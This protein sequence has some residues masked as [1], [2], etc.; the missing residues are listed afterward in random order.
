MSFRRY[1]QWEPGEFVVVG[2]DTATGLGDYCTAQFLS[3]TK[4][5]VPLVYH[6][7]TIATEMTPQLHMELLNIKKMT[8]VRPVIAIERNNGGVFEVDRLAALN[9]TGDYIIYQMKANVGLTDRTESGPRLGW[10]TNSATRP[11]M[12][13]MLKEAVDKKLIR[14]Y[15]KPTIT[16]MFSF[17]IKTTTATVKAQAEAGAH[18]DLIMAMSI[19]W[20]LFQTENPPL[21]DEHVELTPLFD[22]QGFYI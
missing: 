14:I 1:R 7:K 18:D 21:Q 9:R 13:Q 12:L 11:I 6:S 15:D 8:G 20:Q 17:V 16:E 2:A 22:A 10:D 4:L 3:K 5:D 19:A